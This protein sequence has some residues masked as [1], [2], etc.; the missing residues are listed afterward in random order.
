ML[1]HMVTRDNSWWLST[2]HSCRCTS[3][4]HE[5]AHALWSM[6]LM[7]LFTCNP[8]DMRACFQP[9]YLMDMAAPHVE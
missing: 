4:T 1:K 9:F 2:A 8:E 7:G 5:L 6:M 3:T